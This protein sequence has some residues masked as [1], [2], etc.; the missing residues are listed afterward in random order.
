MHV[1]RHLWLAS[2]LLVAPSLAVAQQT[3]NDAS[4]SGKVTDESGGVVAGA[5]VTARHLQ[6]SVTSATMTDGSGHFRFPSLRIGPYELSVTCAGFARVTR[7]MTLTA[8]SAFTLPIALPLAGLASD[9]IVTAEAALLES[10]RSQVAV[11]VPEPELRQL[12]LNG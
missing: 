9:V 5:V 6:T 11:T 2:A 8:G 4:I 12:P 1:L 7:P 10:A 3:V